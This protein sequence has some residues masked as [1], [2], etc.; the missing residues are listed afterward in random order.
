MP[1]NTA[2]RNYPYPLPADPVAISALQDLAE[3]IDDDITANLEPETRQRVY[4]SMR[5]AATQAILPN[6][7]TVLGFQTELK[8]TDDMI[9]VVGAP[10]I[11]TVNTSGFYAVVGFITLSTTLNWSNVILRFRLNGTEMYS[12]TQHLRTTDINYIDWSI[13]SSFPCAAGDV[14]TMT[15]SHNSPATTMSLP[16]QREFSAL[17]MAT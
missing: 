1:A 5:G 13:H 10:T 16:P 14:I 2:N 4:G 7:E 9:D 15:F 17:R 12:A 11:I 3:A 6:V 8:D